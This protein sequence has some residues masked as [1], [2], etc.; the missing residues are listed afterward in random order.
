MSEVANNSSGQLL[1]ATQNG[2]D[3]ILFIQRRVTAP[4]FNHLKEKMMLACLF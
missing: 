1:H 4:V 2:I 3:A